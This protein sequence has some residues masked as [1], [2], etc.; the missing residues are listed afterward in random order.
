MVMDQSV[1]C[2]VSQSLENVSR[3]TV[4]SKRMWIGALESFVMILFAQMR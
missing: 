1:I 2:L 4:A 3:D